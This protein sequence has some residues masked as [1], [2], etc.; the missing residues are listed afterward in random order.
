ME[1][2]R[3]VVRSLQK[4]SVTARIG[5]EHAQQLII[6]NDFDEILRYFT[7]LIADQALRAQSVNEVLAVEC[8]RS[9][10]G[11]RFCYQFNS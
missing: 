5:V 6:R 11:S 4:W 1:P 3:A 2:P 7:E 9:D 10:N 8:W